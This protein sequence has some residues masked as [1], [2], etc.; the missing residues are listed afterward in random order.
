[1][2]VCVS[3]CLATLYRKQQLSSRVF[4]LPSPSPGHLVVFA[5]TSF[6]HSITRVS[7]F[8]REPTGL[9][10]YLQLHTLHKLWR[11]PRCLHVC[12]SHVFGS[13]R[14][15]RECISPQLKWESFPANYSFSF[16]VQQ[17]VCVCV[18]VCVSMCIILL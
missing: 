17:H 9:P 7:S 8:E 16:G 5:L 11:S 14:Y 18:C 4:P 15:L 3:L 2:F 10:T 6:L 1:M 12:N 13:C